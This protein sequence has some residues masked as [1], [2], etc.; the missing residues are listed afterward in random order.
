MR[1]VHHR[2]KVKAPKTISKESNSYKLPVAK[3]KATQMR[4]FALPYN[5]ISSLTLTDAASN[6]TAQLE[7][8]LSNSADKIS[9][10]GTLFDKI[11][12]G[13]HNFHG[14][15]ETMNCKRRHLEIFDCHRLLTFLNFAQQ[16]EGI[17]QSNPQ[18]TRSTFT[19]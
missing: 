9:C 4:N 16:S 17:L 14:G 7:L 1:C 11:L 13:L 3:M 6:N 19:N 8:K 10:Q 5:M 15:S 12:H 18:S 2:L